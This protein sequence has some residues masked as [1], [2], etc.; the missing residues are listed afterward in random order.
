MLELSLTEALRRVEA[1][2]GLT[3][4]AS[5]HAG[6]H[7]LVALSATSGFQRA[8]PATR[9]LLDVEETRNARRQVHGRLV[10][11]MYSE[12][13]H[14][15]IYAFEP[16]PAGSEPKVVVWCVHT[17]VYEWPDFSR[18]MSWVNQLCDRGLASK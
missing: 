6:A 17:T 15:D 10:P 7:A 18:F 12:A 2:L 1:A 4:P 9:L 5:F 14:P 13:Q 3:Y 8:F 16:G 11:F